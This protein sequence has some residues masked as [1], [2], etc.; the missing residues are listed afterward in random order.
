MPEQL[1]S[2]Q[3]SWVGVRDSSLGHVR[4]LEVS[5]AGGQRFILSAGAFIWQDWST[6]R[7][8]SSSQELLCPLPGPGKSFRYDYWYNNAKARTV[9]E[10]EFRDKKKTAKDSIE[11]LKGARVWR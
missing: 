11:N 5:A 1:A 10:I 4:A 6:L 9:F 3:G 2:F 8:S 7:T